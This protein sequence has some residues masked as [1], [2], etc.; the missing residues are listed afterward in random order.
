MIEG[1]GTVHGTIGDM[2]AE[3]LRSILPIILGLI[4]LQFALVHMPTGMFIQ[5]L[6]GAAFTVV[7]FFL[8]LVGARTGLL[9]LGEIIGSTVPQR[10]SAALLIST[11]FAVGTAVTIAEPDV[12]ILG[13]QVEYAYGGAIGTNLLIY[14]VALGVGVSL[15]LAVLRILLG[16]RIAW[17]FAA[18]YGIVFALAP[19]VPPEFAPIAF[20][21]GGVTTGPVT[22]PFIL[23]FGLGTSSVLRGHSREAI[24]GFGM[25]GLASIGPII[26]VMILGV[27]FG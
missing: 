8:F 12:R 19:F 18:G 25:V 4:V 5:F 1:G 2:L 6:I 20:D 26:A 17:L 21:A 24:D 23:A 27:I 15:A 7:G 14:V 10:G 11:A 13:Y 9:P 22:V 3:V 16:V